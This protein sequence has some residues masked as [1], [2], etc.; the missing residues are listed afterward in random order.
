VE[1]FTFSNEIFGGY[2]T[3]QEA[4]AFLFNKIHGKG[5]WEQNPFV[6]VYDFELTNASKS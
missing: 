4:Y 5:T 3:P 1:W 6:W 2:N